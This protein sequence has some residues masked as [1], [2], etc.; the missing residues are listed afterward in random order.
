M[1]LLNAVLFSLD[2]IIYGRLPGE[3]INI[4]AVQHWNLKHEQ[5]FRNK[6]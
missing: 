6:I 4:R 3:G 5:L 2:D 1:F